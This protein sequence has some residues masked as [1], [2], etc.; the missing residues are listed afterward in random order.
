MSLDELQSY[1]QEQAGSDDN[2]VG[3]TNWLNNTVVPYLENSRKFD[4]SDEKQATAQFSKDVMFKILDLCK[5][6]TEL[7]EFY[8]Q[9]FYF[10]CKHNADF[11]RQD[12]EQLEDIAD[13]S[14]DMT[15]MIPLAGTIKT[16]EEIETIT[17]QQFG[18][19]LARIG[20][21]G[22]GSTAAKMSKIDAFTQQNSLTEAIWAMED[23]PQSPGLFP[24]EKAYSD[25]NDQ[26]SQPAETGWTQTKRFV[27][28]LFK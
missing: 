27:T 1:F 14:F 18:G 23:N 5:Q 15:R 10:L 16:F 26:A 9:P 21:S 20:V 19:I 7:C 24:R 17:D 11:Y 25:K 13:A 6:D 3:Y 28:R 2:I 4:T 8:R 12:A 22:C